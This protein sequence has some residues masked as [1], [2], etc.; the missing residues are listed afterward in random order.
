M[1][2]FSLVA[3]AILPGALAD[4]S[5]WSGNS[6]DFWG[7]LEVREEVVD[8]SL[9][10]DSIGTWSRLRWVYSSIQC[11][12][13]GRLSSDITGDGRCVVALVPSWGLPVSMDGSSDDW[14][15]HPWISDEISDYSC[16]DTD[17][18][19]S[20]FEL[21]AEMRLSEGKTVV[22]TVIFVKYR[23]Y[24]ASMEDSNLVGIYD[25]GT[26]PVAFSGK[27]ATYDLEVTSCEVGVALHGPICRQVEWFCSVAG[28][29]PVGVT[30]HGVWLLAEKEFW[31]EIE[32]SGWRVTTGVNARYGIVSAQL[33]VGKSDLECTDGG[34]QW[35]WDNGDY[36]DE[37]IL[38]E[39]DL[40]SLNYRISVALDLLPLF[41]AL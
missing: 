2:L 40:E 8:F 3:G 10:I 1:L 34:R 16:A 28:V 29:Y 17:G 15:W 33:L 24:D 21:S 32:G 37:P 41:G 7:G 27:V 11:V 12:I 6:L 26:W 4:E 13:G 23:A 35:G 39:L 25:Y 31:Q 30:G 9:G 5:I 20:W 38:R 36:Y 19:T 14:D 22:D 18:E